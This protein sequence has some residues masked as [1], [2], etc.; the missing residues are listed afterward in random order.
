MYHFVIHLA[1]AFF[2]IPL[3]PECQDQFA[4][5]WEGKEWTFIVLPQGYLHR[6][7]VVMG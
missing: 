1:N 3:A 2:S 6:P 4:F 5:T 7:Q